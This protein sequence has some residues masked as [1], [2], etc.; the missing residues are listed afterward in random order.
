MTEVFDL[1]A[2]EKE[3]LDSNITWLAAADPD[4]WH[5]VVLDFNWG[6]PLYVLDWI[7]RQPQCDIAT[8][9]TVFWKGEPAAW[10]ADEGQADSEPNGFSYLN[11]KICEYIA[12]RI[13]KGGYSRSEIAF[14]PTTW[15]KKDYVD[16]ETVE[17]SFDNPNIR[18]HPELI[19]ERSGRAVDVSADFYARYPIEFHHSYYSEEL[20]DAIEQGQFETPRSIELEKCIG[21]IEQRTLEALPEWLG[22]RAPSASSE[23]ASTGVEQQAIELHASAQIRAIREQADAPTIGPARRGPTGG[24]PGWL[25]RLLGR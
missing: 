11:Q 4:D 25:N 7:V 15:T 9:Q 18:M 8:A 19:R 2:D 24:L 1:D 14:A 3:S 10:L 20:S 12:T 16:L 23:A 5:R 6:E 21:E 17:K 22:G 13:R